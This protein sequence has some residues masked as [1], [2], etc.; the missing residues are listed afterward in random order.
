MDEKAQRIVNVSGGMASAVALFRTI[1]RYGRDGTLAVFADTRSED[2]DTYR[3]LDDVERVAQIPI[4]RLSDGRDI[5]AVF[6]QSALFTTLQGG[7]KASWELKKMPLAAFTEEHGDYETTTILVGFGP[8]ET[9]RMDLLTAAMRPWRVDFPLAWGGYSH[10]C[11]LME[12]LRSRGIEPP[13][14]YARG[15][16]HNNCAGACILAGIKQWSG[17]LRDYRELYLSSEEK[18]QRFL[19]ELR[20]RG[21]TEITI[22][23]DRRGG[24]VEN[25]SLR[26]LREEIESGERE[27]TDSWRATTCSCMGV[28]FAQ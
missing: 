24:S 13:R 27:P 22:L 6:F 4:T 8:D 17:L 28:L 25:L 14:I 26:Q 23:K 20:A 16:P 1:E 19:T 11:D 3:F 15:Y 10:R 2:A 9:N 7:C 18:E 5:W 12:E 21:R